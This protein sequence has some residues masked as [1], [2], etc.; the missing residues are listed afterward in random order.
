LGNAVEAAYRRGDLFEKRRA[1][2]NDWAHYIT[3]APTEKVIQGN[4]SKKSG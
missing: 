3:T 2:M 1:L 4:F